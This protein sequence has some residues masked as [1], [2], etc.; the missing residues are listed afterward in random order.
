M[1]VIVSMELNSIEIFCLVYNLEEF[2]SN[3][4]CIC[5]LDY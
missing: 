2:L 3:K 4:Y 5:I 1:F